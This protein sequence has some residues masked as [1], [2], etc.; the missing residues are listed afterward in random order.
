MKIAIYREK[1]S[2]EMSLESSPAN[3]KKHLEFL[4]SSNIIHTRFYT[5]EFFLILSLNILM[6]AVYG[7]AL[8]DVTLS[9]S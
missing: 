3:S 7:L 2:M 8:L 4:P 9:E 6:L 5:L 1:G